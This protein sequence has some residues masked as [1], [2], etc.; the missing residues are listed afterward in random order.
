M[1]VDFEAADKPQCSMIF[2]RWNI[3]TPKIP[4]TISSIQPAP[5]I[6]YPFYW[7]EYL[8]F[9]EILL[10]NSYNSGIYGSLLSQQNHYKIT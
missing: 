1:T 2:C 8:E 4:S 7:K 6:C 3:R 10:V 5:N 9:Y